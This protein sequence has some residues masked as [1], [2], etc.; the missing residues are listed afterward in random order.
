MNEIDPYLLIGNPTP[1]QEATAQRGATPGSP[2][3]EQPELALTP[4]SKGKRGRKPVQVPQDTC[5]EI[6]RLN[7]FYS[8]RQIAR[9][10]S[11]RRELVT[12]VLQARG[13]APLP[14]RSRA[15]KQESKLDRFRE[16]IAQRV[17][18]RLTT[19]RILREIRKVGYQGRRSILGVYVRALRSQMAL[20]PRKGVKR[21]FETEPG[22]EMQIDW[23]PYD[24]PIGRRTVRI[25]VL[26]CLLA[27][28]RKLYV[29]AYRDERQSTLLEALAS[30]FEYFDGVA[31]RAVLDNMA[32]AVVGRV[33]SDRNVLWNQRFLDFV[34]H[35]GTDPFA[36]KVNDPDRKGKKEKSFRLLFDDFIKATE[37][38]SWD[39]LHEQLRIWLDET[40]EVANLRVHGTTG[41][42]PNEAFELEHPHLIRLPTQR[43]AVHEESARGVD[44]DSTLW[45]RGTPYTV[46]AALADRSVA[47]RLFAEHFEVLDP[48]GRVAFSRC[49]VPDEEKGKLVID[50]THYANLP[51]RPRGS[52]SGERLDEAFLRR[53]PELQALVDGLKR[54]MKS[55]APIHLRRMLRQC[56]R[57]G[58]EAFLTAARRAQ[59]YRRFDALAIERIL[60]RAHPGTAAELSAAEPIAPVTGHGAAALG[61]VD[62]G[63]LESFAALDEASATT[64]TPC[65]K[66]TNSHGS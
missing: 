33:G 55:L 27:W 44:S 59:G 12:R 18:K 63:S 10:V 57:Y 34:R 1:E 41:R 64:H 45:I 6:L 51:R 47:V 50:K 25:Y 2:T 61:E 11:L 32:T 52:G 36:C 54:R 14:A 28:S 42:V 60:E 39:D 9:R 4:K 66:E 40:P 8:V 46:P 19:T 3:P 31:A 24:V 43:F 49:Y 35:Y 29:R 21:R 37:F 56:D 15:S 58:Q 53:F 22:E 17:Q 30:A 23:S 38:A 62:C 20:Q 48:H 26:G 13:R 16:L 65:T 7:D 5:D